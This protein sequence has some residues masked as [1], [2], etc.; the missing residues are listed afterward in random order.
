MR[1]GNFAGSIVRALYT[2]HTDNVNSSYWVGSILLFY[3][4]V[5]GSNAIS[6]V[7]ANS[8]F[9]TTPA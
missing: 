5:I 8:Y 1:D 6:Y 4:T 2:E 9:L 7:F 3:Y